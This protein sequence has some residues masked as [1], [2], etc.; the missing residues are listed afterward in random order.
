MAMD[1][2]WRLTTMQSTGQFQSQA[3]TQGPSSIHDQIQQQRSV[4][5]GN[6]LEMEPPLM[7]TRGVLQASGVSAAWRKLLLQAD[8]AAPHV[9]LAS[10]EGESGVGKQTLARYLLSRSP[11][12]GAG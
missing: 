9:Q 1:A 6:I 3:A 7:G 12:S 11:L 8:M 10:I 2:R 5:G 4:S